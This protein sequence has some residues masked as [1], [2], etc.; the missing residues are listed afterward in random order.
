MLRDVKCDVVLVSSAPVTLPM[1]A[2]AYLRRRKIPYVYVVYDMDPDRA[3][4]LGIADPHGLPV[5]ALSWQQRKWLHGA[6]TVVAI[7]RC[8][9]DHLMERYEV[10]PDRIEVIEV[11]ADAYTV[12]PLPRNTK[13]RREN[14]IDGFIVL[15]SG[16]FGKYHDF[17]T[18]LDAAKAV[19]SK[20][21]SVTFVLVGRGAKKE[22][23]QTRIA[24]ERI[25]NVKMFDF[26]PEEDYA[27]LIASADVCLVTLEAGMEGLCVPSKF[28]SILAGGRPTL[29][30]MRAKSEVAY[31]V[32]GED[33]G[34]VVEL[35]DSGQLAKTVLQLT[36]K[37]EEL[38]VQGDRARYLFEAR[39][40]SDIIAQKFEATLSKAAAKNSRSL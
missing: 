26:V 33:I 13:F 10:P 31:A 36:T 28:Y 27:D 3:V 2:L 30:L 19:W 34:I 1:A 39:Y 8:M 16:N 32:D 11:G 21:P 18:V 14:E 17:D 5:R 23:L 12:R 9:R 7:G 37:S 38:R 25:H 15:Y 4:A 22:H 29:A 6:H 20:K 24:T 40:T 35:G